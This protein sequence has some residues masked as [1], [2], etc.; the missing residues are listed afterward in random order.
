MNQVIERHNQPEHA[1]PV[2]CLY[3]RKL[4]PVL[5]FDSPAVGMICAGCH[6]RLT[7]L[8]KE[9]AYLPRHLRAQL[10]VTSKPVQCDR[11]QCLALVFANSHVMGILC[12]HCHESLRS[13]NEEPVG[14]AREPPVSR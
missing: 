2:R 8:R 13:A 5:V 4:V 12:R 14:D 6:R 3:C 10:S 1:R 7:D 9:A 11:C